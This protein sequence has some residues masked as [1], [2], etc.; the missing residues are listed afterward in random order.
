MLV[1]NSPGGT[2]T[3]LCHKSVISVF[4]NYHR[5]PFI[6]GCAWRGLF[7]TTSHWQMVIL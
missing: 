6:S 3:M 4:S 7:F 2:G 1:L 5:Y